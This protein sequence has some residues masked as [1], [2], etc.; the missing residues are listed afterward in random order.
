MLKFLLEKEFKQIMRNPFLPKMIIILPFMMLL[1]IPWA[2][3]MEIK[4][5]K[6]AIIDND[7]STY[8]RR[9]IHKVTA[10]GYFILEN[11]SSSYDEALSSIE[12][13][14]TDIIFEISPDF[15][16]NLVN[17]GS[18]EVLVSANAVNGTKGGLG[19]SYVTSILSDFSKDLQAEEGVP[20]VDRNIIPSINVVTN[21]KFNIYLDYK[22]FMIPALIVMLLTL[23]TGFLP[24]F[25]IVGEKEIGTIEQ[26]NVS[27]VNR[28][29]FILG[30]IIPYWII[31]YIVLTIGFIVATLLYGLTP[32]GSYLLIYFYAAIY[33][34]AVSGLGLIISNY[35]DTLQQSMFV[36]FFFI[37]ILVLLS[38]LFT[39]ISS[40]PEWAKWI[41]KINPLSYFMQV[42]RGIYLKGSGL[43]DLLPQLIALCI[44]G[45]VFNIWA[46]LS[47]KKSI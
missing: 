25:N 28:I 14:R 30:K 29:V 47:Y 18:A 35:S 32:Q 42:M 5:A 10:S 19:V 27:P 7:N 31:G 2:A 1:V 13:G 3:N 38:G 41:T 17:N 34:L 39:P 23:I 22:A 11:I 21:N 26:M 37:L 9:L 43:H 20:S 15:E 44:F 12:S 36:M 16:K 8:S 45:V 40:M 24:A 46:I 4:N 6:L 33:I